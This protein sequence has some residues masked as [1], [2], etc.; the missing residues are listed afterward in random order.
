MGGGEIKGRR[1]FGQIGRG[2]F[3]CPAEKVASSLARREMIHWGRREEEHERVEHQSPEV[4]GQRKHLPGNAGHPVHGRRRLGQGGHPALR[5]AGRVGGLRH[6]A[7]RAAAERRSA[8]PAD[9]GR[10]QLHCGRPALDT[11]KAGQLDAAGRERGRLHRHDEARPIH[12][13]R[14]HRHQQ[15]H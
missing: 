11:G 2:V 7:A 13:L 15:H 5:G 3:V 4:T 9:A 12:L 10:K 1:R 6:H 8:G 14:D